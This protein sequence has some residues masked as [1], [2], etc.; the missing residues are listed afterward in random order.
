M[1]IEILTRYTAQGQPYIEWSLFTGPD[2]I[3]H[4]HGYARDLIQAFSKIL[5]WNTRIDEEYIEE[6]QKD[7]NTLKNW[8]NTE[9]ETLSH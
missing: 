3:E 9:N 4:I 8:I 1:K 5:E 2:G 7:L 6:F